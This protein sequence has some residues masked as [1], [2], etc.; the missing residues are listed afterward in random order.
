MKTTVI[1]P[2]LFLLFTLSIHAQ[3]IPYGMK[4]QAVARD[5]AG[6]V[7]ANQDIHL[8]ITLYS[9]ADRT[10]QYSETHEV[11]TSK[12]GLFSLTIGEGQI[13]KGTFDAVPWSSSNIWMKLAID[14]S[15]GDNFTT[16]SD[17]KLLAV[18]YA[19][20]A[21]TAD[22]LTG[23]GSD[24]G[25]RAPGSDE[26]WSLGGNDISTVDPP[27]TE[28]HTL[29]TLNDHDLIL[30]VNNRP[31]MR[32]L[33]E[34]GH[35]EVLNDHIV[36]ND[37][38]VMNDVTVANNQTIAKN[39]AVGNDLNVENK[40]TLGSLETEGG[41]YLNSVN[42]ST[43]IEG[44]TVLKR[45]LDVGE[46]TTLWHTLD[47]MNKSATN[48]TGTLGVDGLTH[49]RNDTESYDI[50]EGALLVE[51][52]TGI[53][54]NLNVGGK[55]KFSNTLSVITD[56]QGASEFDGH[57]AHFENK[58]NGNGVQIKVGAAVPH[59]NNNFITFLNSNN[60]AVGRVEGEYG[61]E[62]LANNLGYLDALDDFDTDIALA[63]SALTITTAETVMTG[64]DI[65]IATADV[66][67]AVA[68]IASATAEVAGAAGSTT[69][70]GGIGGCVTSPIPSL[71]SSEGASLVIAI[72]NGVV[73][74]VNLGLAA[75]NGV[76]ALANEGLAIADLALVVES[77]ETFIDHYMMEQGVTFASGAGDY[78]EYLPKLNPEIDFMPGEVVG[79]KNGLISKK[80]LGADRVMVISF[81]PA[82]LGAMPSEGEE[83]NYEKV[84]FL[85]QIPTRIM[86]NV[87][88]GD[89]IL[90][91]GFHNGLAIARHPDKMLLSDYK[92][93]LGVAWERAE[94]AGVNLVNVAVGLNVNDFSNVIQEQQ[95]ELN[96]LKNQMHQTNEILAQ[97]VP[98]FK[99][100]ANLEAV[101]MTTRA[102]DHDGHGHEAEART[103][104]HQHDFLTQHDVA[105]V[106][107]DESTIV[108]YV[109]ERKEYIEW[110]E[111]ARTIFEDEKIDMK[112]H[113]FWNRLDTDPDYLEEVI[114]E[115]ETRFERSIHYH[116]DINAGK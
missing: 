92:K 39:L 106:K 36:G 2:I 18:P 6:Q 59:N 90:P 104:E 52:G 46:A 17:S 116:V 27:G 87:E 113:P 55:G 20:H 61:E 84:A 58:D 57:V 4:Y 77:K 114:Q 53:K 48:M 41:V 95:Q 30:V 56:G 100:A 75:G 80:T 8:K 70:C 44:E 31:A 103:D 29:G 16:I 88:R 94:G 11:Q 50:G 1:F 79:L 37:L 82:V 65:A 66:G 24:V 71:I 105:M 9:Q 81:K 21:A 112:E 93:I 60:V 96:A 108:Y 73:A 49:L 43:I 98:G 34:N 3:S 14:E 101:E 33:A 76:I 78:A 10:V 26:Y 35:V 102:T 64:A 23:G 74:G 110:I 68:D 13:E 91:S 83:G 111:M 109:P 42:G 54:K 5:H 38:N 107:P 12:L 45:T 19:F 15:G 62:D 7:L 22:Q 40:A 28:L 25:W 115:L 86:G 51:G 67:I 89:Y 99:E 97:L 72:A 47:V 69:V 85:G 63:T 32:I